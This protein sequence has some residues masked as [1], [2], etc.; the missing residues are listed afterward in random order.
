MIFRIDSF[1]KT[2]Y[3]IFKKSLVS[4]DFILRRLKIFC[5]DLILSFEFLNLILIFESFDIKVSF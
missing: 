4:F 5:I 3:L 1:L 2:L